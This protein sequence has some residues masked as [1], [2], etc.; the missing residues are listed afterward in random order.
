MSRTYRR[1]KGEQPDT[2]VTHEMVPI[3]EFEKKFYVFKSGKIEE[4][5]RTRYLYV[6]VP[7][8][9]HALKKS[10][11]KY[12]SDGA[13]V[14]SSAPSWFVNKY[15]TRKD[16]ARERQELKR[17]MQHGGDYDDYS[18]RPYKKGAMWEWW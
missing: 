9:G 17:I 18:F 6:D 3:E 16:R 15:F 10:L 7:L 2:W 4:R 14:M 8:T 5:I 11:A 13:N 1:K 12:R